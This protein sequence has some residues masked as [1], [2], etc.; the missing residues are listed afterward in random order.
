MFFVFSSVIWLLIKLSKEYR[1]TYEVK[2]N[3]A[4]K[5]KERVITDVSIDQV[6]VTLRGKGFQLLKYNLIGRDMT[7]DVTDAG[8]N[9]V[10]V[11]L[12]SE[13]YKNDLLKEVFDDDA[14]IISVS[15]SKIALTIDTL[16][17]KDVPVKTNIQLIFKNG[18]MLSDSLVTEPPYVTVYGP[19]EIVDTMEI[20]TTAYKSIE[21]IEDGFTY[22]IPLKEAAHEK[23]SYSTK[24]VTVVGK[25]ERFTED[26]ID[27]PV[28]FINVPS[29][30]TIKSFPK[31]VPVLIKGSFVD[32]KKVSRNDFD[33]ICDYDEID[34]T[35]TYVKTKLNR[36]PSNIQIVN[37]KDDNFQVLI[38]TK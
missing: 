9:E 16:T 2:L 15:P 17:S 26:E 25:V 8:I 11:N 12:S 31:E 38:K 4:E 22:D 18:Y 23:L 30:V 34:S 28:R 37:I 36:K 20:I 14:T 19:A 13:K 21:D 24:E 6:S 10:S 35:S 29:N 27:L 32:L 5:N 33:L 1:A 7:V 3:Y